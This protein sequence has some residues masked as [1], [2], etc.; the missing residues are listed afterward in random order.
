MI[1]VDGVAPRTKM[2]QQRI[3]RYRKNTNITNE[4]LE[5]IK[6]KGLDISNQF[7]SDAISAGTKFMF[8]LT[9]Y[10]K[11]F[12]IEKKKKIQNGPK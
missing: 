1:S 5:V 2:N 4:E 6:E 7:N 12:I 11:N 3:R 9:T 10:L 8:D